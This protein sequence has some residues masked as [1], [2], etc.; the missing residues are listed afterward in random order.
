MV[1]K[2]C[3]KEEL[4]KKILKGVD[5]LTDNVASTLGPRGRNVILH[6]RGKNPLITKDGVTVARFIDLTD[7]VE[8]L[9]VQIVKQASSQT[10][11]VAGDGT[12][13]ATVL[14]RAILRDSQKYLSS[15]VPPNEF[16]KGIDKAVDMICENLKAMARPIMSEEDITHIA[17]VS[18]NN[19]EA[20]GKLVALAVDKV[21]KDGAI[22]VE[23]ARS[24]DS[25]LDIIE[26]FRFNSGYI[27]NMF[28]TDE[29]RGLVKHEN[30]LLLV[31]DESIETVE[32]MLPALE[33]AA[34]EKRS[35]LV[36]AEEIQGQALA[37]LIMN[38]V[39]GTMK[40]VAVKA[41]RYG[42]ERRSIL[43]DL[44]ISVGA[45]L[46]SREAGVSLQEV[47]LEHFGNARRIEVFKN[48]T[49]IAG[50]LGDSDAIDERIEALKCELE[51]TDNLHE[52]EKI[53]ERITRLAS[54]VAV[55]KV[56]APTEVEML[57]KKHRIE[58][59]LEAVRSAQ[60]EGIIPGGGVALIRA[61]EDLDINAESEAQR[62]GMN[63]VK[64]AAT[65]PLRQM[66]L[67][68]G[69]SPD[70]IV[71]TVKDASPNC[72]YDFL[73]CKVVDMIEVGIIDPVKVTRVALQ[74]AAS[75]A[76]ILLTTEHAIIEVD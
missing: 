30:V 6:Q 76:S 64:H 41:P 17:S 28:V 15:G 57:E 74:N 63:V 18:A 32:D 51:Q 44:A 8:N 72:G 13:T 75:A 56:G 40:V 39:R 38:A 9:G 24:I 60:I 45:T 12:T 35:L 65:E 21:G 48:F 3:S 42:E 71:A 16:K 66:A 70:I 36:V 19:D 22:T 11:N 29:R 73:T 69:V 55:I 50:G 4:R 47:K 54:G 20:I 2:Y 34:R 58:D 10:N 62:M 52:C 61:A 49:T 27:S 33:L 5:E 31:T 46:I 23:E 25:S 1:K 43:K 7:P 67:N 26:G 59:A 53:Q 37:A 68:A 14:S